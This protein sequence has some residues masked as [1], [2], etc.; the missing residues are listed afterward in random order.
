MFRQLF[1]TAWE[2]NYIRHGTLSPILA[3]VE[4]PVVVRVP[5]T[6]VMVVVRVPVPV[7]SP[8]VSLMSLMV[9]PMRFSNMARWARAALDRGL[10]FLGRVLIPMFTLHPS[11]II[12]FTLCLGFIFMFLPVV[13]FVG[14]MFT[15]V[16]TLF[17]S[18]LDRRPD[19]GRRERWYGDKDRRSNRGAC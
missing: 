2:V 10:R 8:N 11:L 13:G 5:V 19:I 1:I 3:P 12:L 17:I 15:L 4:V 6:L 9:G 18:V 14:F 7:S 16:L